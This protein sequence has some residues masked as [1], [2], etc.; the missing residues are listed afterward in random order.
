M[1]THDA[2]SKPASHQR[3]TDKQEQSRP[4]HSPGVTK[5][6][7]PAHAVLVNEVDDDHAEQR[8]YAGDPVDERD[9]YWGRELRIFPRRVRMRR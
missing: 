6:L 1:D 3:E 2:P 9:V 4:P 8:A 7:L 5:S